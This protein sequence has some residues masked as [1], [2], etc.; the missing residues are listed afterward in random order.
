[1]PGPD[2]GAV[3]PPITEYARLA[4]LEGVT[5][6]PLRYGFGQCALD[7]G[8]DLVSVSELLGRQR[9]ETTAIYPTASRRDL[10]RAVEKLE[11]DVNRR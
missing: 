7:A 1:M 2:S 5:L 4:G 10:E 11:Q 6:H 9:R 3:E 8:A